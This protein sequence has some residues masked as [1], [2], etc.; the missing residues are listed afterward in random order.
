MGATENG[1]FF[2]CNR[3][4][5]ETF[6]FFGLTKVKLKRERTVLI[7]TRQLSPASRDR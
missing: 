4:R 6:D 3:K 5:I 1:S 7:Q 2:E